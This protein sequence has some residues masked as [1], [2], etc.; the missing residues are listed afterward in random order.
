VTDEALQGLDIIADVIRKHY[1]ISE[2]GMPRQFP[3]AHQRRHRKMIVDTDR[4]RFLAKTYSRD[5]AVIDALLFQHRLSAHL[6]KHRLPVARILKAKSGKGLVEIDDWAMELQEFVD[7]AAMPVTSKTLATAAKALGRFHKVCEGFPTPPRDANLWRF[8]EVP[9]KQLQDLYE[10][11]CLEIDREQAAEWCNRLVLFLN[12]AAKALSIENRS[13][14]EIGLIHG[15]WHGGNLLFHNEELKAIIDL[16]FA[17]IGC[18]LE[19]IA[20]GISNLCIRTTMNT[21]KMA[22]RTNILLDN[23]QI[24]RDLSWSEKVALYYAVGL[25]HI[26]TVSYQLRQLQGKVAGYTAGQ[27]LERLVFQAEW[28]AE[29]SRKI[30][31]GEA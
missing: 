10:K 8:S 31:F 20:Y 6:D 16:E 5:T 26:T 18:Y 13:E 1:D 29:R 25:K 7:G 24:S 22:M 23:Y 30:R 9:R 2:V 21:G 27:W 11:A 28:L 19:D 3:G 12:D 15:D 14:F 17:G 4:G